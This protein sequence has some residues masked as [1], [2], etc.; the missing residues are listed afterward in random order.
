MTLLAVDELSVSYGPIPA[1]RGVS[2]TIDE[3]EVVALVG[4][5]GAGKSTTLNALMGFVPTSGTIRLEGR[6]VS[7]W[8]TERIVRAGMT[9]SPEG[10]QIFARLTVADNL[11]LGGAS[12][13]N[14]SEAGRRRDELLGIFPVLLKRERQLAGTLSGGEQQQLAIARAL[15]SDP[16]LLLLD[17][18]SLGLAPQMVATIFN[19]I[20]TLRDRG[21]TVF[22]VEQN[23]EGSL[24]VADRGYVLENG[25]IAAAGSSPELRESSEIARSYLGLGAA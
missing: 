21:L 16:K 4:V 18:P 7:G 15:M 20:E 17:E 19:L 24:R 13:R 9:L 3:G 22:V 14:R 2:F 12:A 11:T 25:R 10:R 23:V 8:P 6:D 5:N 1:L